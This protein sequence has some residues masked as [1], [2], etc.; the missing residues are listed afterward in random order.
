M[1]YFMLQL[2]FCY[3]G[4]YNSFVVLK[5][6]KRHNVNVHSVILALFQTPT[7]NYQTQTHTL[8][9]SISSLTP[10]VDELHQIS[11]YVFWQNI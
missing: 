2:S 5:A 1:L 6:V 4:E 7:H 9:R 11:V 8:C 3:K 10:D